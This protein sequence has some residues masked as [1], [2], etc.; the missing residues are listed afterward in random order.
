MY[1][2]KN[3]FIFVILIS[4]IL[5]S[6]VLAVEGLTGVATAEINVNGKTYIFPVGNNDRKADVYYLKKALKGDKEALEVFLGDQE[7]RIFYV[8]SETPLWLLVSK[9]GTFEIKEII[10]G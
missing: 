9:D 8:G 10:G 1:I 6:N 4:L 2:I 5:S 7:S 3:N